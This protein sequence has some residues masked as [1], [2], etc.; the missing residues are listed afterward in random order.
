MALIIG[1]VATYFVW[2]KNASPSAKF[3]AR[4]D[5]N[6]ASARNQ[7]RL[8]DRG[9][10]TSSKPSKAYAHPNDPSLINPAE[11][12]RLLAAAVE[13][14]PDI[15]QRSEYCGNL[16]RQLCLAG[17][18]SEAWELIQASAGQV[19]NL[20][21]SAY[22]ES[23]TL[24]DGKLL[25]KIRE[26]DQPFD[27]GVAFDAF[28]SR[29]SSS[30]VQGFLSSSDFKKYLES[31][32]PGFAVELSNSISSLLQGELIMSDGSNNGEI[33]NVASKLHASKALTTDGLMEVI[34]RDRSTGPFDKWNVI[35][36]LK[37]STGEGQA[38]R[39]RILNG[40]VKSDAVAAMSQILQSPGDQAMVDMQKITREWTK[41]DSRG[42]FEWYLNNAEAITKG[43]RSGIAMGFFKSALDIGEFDVARQ[44]AERVEIPELR[45]GALKAIDTKTKTKTKT[46]TN[47]NK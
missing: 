31:M 12:K 29:F 20:E 27:R 2:H 47:Q 9:E 23:S 41:I 38:I 45:S 34:D 46:K 30:E 22:F 11:V 13:N 15:T 14:M 3:G 37:P 26:L 25:A 42:A 17:F 36:G 43:Q 32:G 18:S 28:L 19:R 6:A 8:P 40:M 10:V 35:S 16:I 21:I 39:D 44:W 1:S 7:R 33:L 4:P 24:K 5:N